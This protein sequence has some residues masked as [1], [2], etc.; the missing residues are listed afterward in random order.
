MLYNPTTKKGFDAGCQYPFCCEIR[1]DQVERFLVKKA[2]MFSTFFF[3]ELFG[4]MSQV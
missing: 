4:N 1:G 3:L 2:V